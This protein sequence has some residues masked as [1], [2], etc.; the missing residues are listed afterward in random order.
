[1]RAVRLEKDSEEKPWTRGRTRFLRVVKEMQE[2]FAAADVFV[3]PTIYDPFSNASLEAMAAGLPVITTEGNGFAEVMRPGEDGEV[4]ANPADVQGIAQAIE[5]WSAQETAASREARR[6]E[7]RKYTIERN[8]QETLE[9][10]VK[11][12]NS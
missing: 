12:E 5:K 3:L 1:M 8:V 4:L 9:A 6:A 2:L 10:L 7:A 11:L